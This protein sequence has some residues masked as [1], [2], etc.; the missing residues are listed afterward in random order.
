MRSR[1]SWGFRSYLDDADGNGVQLYWD[2]PKEVWPKNK[3]GGLDMFIIPLDVA[4]LLS[5]VE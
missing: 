1:R 2:R 4:N 3:K 5:L